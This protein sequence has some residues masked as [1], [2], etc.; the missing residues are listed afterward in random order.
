M[1]GN[2]TEVTTDKLIFVEEHK[3]KVVFRNPCGRVYR[4][5]IVDGCLIQDGIRADYLVS[6]AKSASVIVE[7]NGSCVEHACE[8]LFVTAEH[9]SIKPLL[10]VKIGFIVMCSKYPRFDT[11]VR[12]AKDRCRKK[13]KCGFHVVCT[14]REFDIDRVVAIDGP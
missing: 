4:K 3:R 10:E 6:E 7:L 5:T 12:K 1:S 13:Y 8:Q 14:R 2:C 11:F 9:P